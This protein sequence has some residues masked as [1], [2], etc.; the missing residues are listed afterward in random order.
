MWAPSW[1]WVLAANALLGVVNVVTRSA[2]QV[3]PGV[4]MLLGSG[5]TRGAI[6]AL[7][8]GGPSAEVVPCLARY[9][10]GAERQLVLATT[11]RR[12]STGMAMLDEP[13][14]GLSPLNVDRL[15]ETVMALKERF[16]LDGK[17]SDVV[18]VAPDAGGVRV[19]G[20][21]S[22][23]FAC[24]ASTMASRTSSVSPAPSVSV[25]SSVELAPNSAPNSSQLR[26]A[27]G[28]P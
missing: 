16:G 1:S 4:A 21:D 11:G 3:S 9:P 8:A 23:S 17:D 27:H 18:I 2:R 10:Q 20:R 5:R 28:V 22:A 26:D 14:A 15:L 7:P 25:T 6:A 19:M 24:S 13:A 12:V